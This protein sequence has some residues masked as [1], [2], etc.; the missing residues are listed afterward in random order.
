MSALMLA[1]KFLKCE[2]FMCICN[3]N[4]QLI[5]VKNLFGYTSVG[6]EPRWEEILLLYAVTLDLL[7]YVQ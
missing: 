4:L 5:N 2:R 3:K 1:D 7:L 6:M